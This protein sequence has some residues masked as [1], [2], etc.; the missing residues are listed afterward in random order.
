MRNLAILL[1][2]AAANVPFELAHAGGDSNPSSNGIVASL[3]QPPPTATVAA[4][5]RQKSEAANFSLKGLDGR[6]HSLGD[7]KGKVIVLNFWAT[8][9]SPCLYEIGDFVAYQE[10]YEKQGLQIIGIGMDEEQK[11]RNVQRTLEINYPILIADPIRNG[12]LM[13]SWGN[14]SGVVP[15]SVVIDRSGRI[16]FTL[17]GLM[18]SETF[19]ENILPLL[20]GA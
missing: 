7:W 16:A 18:S 9:C 2:L 14:K 12:N 4:K 10:K 19:N 8:W 11:L 1:C 5:Q 6:N 15:Y 3:H 20:N 17:H 13:E